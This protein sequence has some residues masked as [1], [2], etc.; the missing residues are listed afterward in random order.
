M[1]RLQRALSGGA[2]LAEWIS[3]GMFM[4]IFVLFIAAVVM[5]YVFVRPIEWADEYILILFLWTT[6]LTE[7]LV[8]SEREQ[9]T[10]D[11][12]YDLCGP[13]GRRGIGL[14]ASVLVTALFLLAMP[15]VFS[16]I[17]FLWREKTP[18]MEWRL[19]FIFA[20]FMVYWVAV[21][22]RAIAK[23]AALCGPRWREHVASAQPDERANVL[24]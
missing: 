15:T 11:V 17:T 5:R 18:V 24:G 10:F 4:A 20:C 14:V 13:A 23:F 9:V 6:F 8:L 19:D 21:C 12:V 22:V 1:N 3:V 16:Y 2:R 7:A